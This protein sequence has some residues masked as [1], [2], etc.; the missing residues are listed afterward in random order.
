MPAPDL[1]E[2]LLRSPLIHWILGLSLLAQLAAAAMA[3]RLTRISGWYVPALLMTLGLL[4]MALRRALGWYRLVVAGPWPIDLLLEVLGLFVSVTMW[5]GLWW[6]YPLL[7]SDR[8]HLKMLMALASV[9]ALTQLPNRRALDI[10]LEHEWRRGARDL[11][12]LSIIMVDVDHFK[13]YNDAYGH[14]QGDNV[15][16]Q[17]GRVI[18]RLA[19]RAGDIPT[20]YGGEEFLIIHAHT[21]PELAARLAERIREGVERLNIPHASGASGVVTVSLGVAT[22][23]PMAEGN[24]KALVDAA[25][26]ALYRAKDGGRNRVV[27]AGGGLGLEA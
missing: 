13:A 21:P 26:T 27:V 7:K 24:P 18:R 22:A 3:F 15:L 5:V 23:L 25:D 9:D 6:F 10:L 4:A 11:H 20:R 19:R 1:L 12:P 16:R 8:H 14:T 17:V 2:A